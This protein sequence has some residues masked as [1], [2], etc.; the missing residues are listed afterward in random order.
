MPLTF[1]LSYF[2]SS[3]FQTK[4]ITREKAL[5]ILQQPTYPTIDEE[6]KDIKYFIKKMKWTSEDLK[7]YIS[8]SEKNHSIYGTEKYLWERLKKIYQSSN[9]LKFLIKKYI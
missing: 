8:K 7:N 4:E 1:R 9:F 3:F 5:R 6:K 2:S